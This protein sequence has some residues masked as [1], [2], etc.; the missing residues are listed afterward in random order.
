MSM[1]SSFNI[2]GRVNLGGRKRESWSW[3][4]FGLILCFS[5]RSRSLGEIACSSS[6]WI[7]GPQSQA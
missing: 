6:A 7:I 2:V 4:S 1:V 3:Q 5:G